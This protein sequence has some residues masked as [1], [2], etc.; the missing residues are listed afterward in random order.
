MDTI[1]KIT[2]CIFIV[3]FAVFA[4]TLTYTAY[5]EF[6]YRNTL[7]GNYT[8]LCSVTTDAPLYNVTLFI[9][10]PVDETGNSPVA[11]AFSSR[12]ITGVP[13]DWETTLFDTGKSTLVKITAPAI[14][15]P[16]G[17][18]AT[19]PYSVILSC[20]SSSRTPVDTRDPVRYSAMFLPVQ[21]LRESSCPSGR[22]GSSTRCFTFNTAVFAEYTTAADTNVRITSA[23]AGRNDWTVFEPASNEYRAEVRI[24][25]RGENHGWGVMD[26]E[27]V[28]GSGS[29]DY[30]G[31]A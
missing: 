19:R 11:A 29:Y 1:I 25:M 9:P 14:L 23:L 30:P 21:G 18:S 3:I 6:A 4:G 8:Y 27:L 5:T 12:S 10:V 2:L 7:T 13:P 28:S 20:Q 31:A 17:I 26:G 16:Q 24:S 22:S 15:P